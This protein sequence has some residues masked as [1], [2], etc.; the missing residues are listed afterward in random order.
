MEDMNLVGIGEN[1]Q[2]QMWE[3]E[4]TQ[5][6]PLVVVYDNGNF[7]GPITHG[8]LLKFDPHWRDP[9]EEE[10]ESIKPPVGLKLFLC[11]NKP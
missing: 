5:L 8:R 11:K 1:S 6:G 10:I 3:I 2:K 7:E 9:T 4:M